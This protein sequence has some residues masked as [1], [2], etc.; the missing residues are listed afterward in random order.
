MYDEACMIGEVVCAFGDKEI[1]DDL[2]D[3]FRGNQK[4]PPVFK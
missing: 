4:D 1:L 3:K 2:H